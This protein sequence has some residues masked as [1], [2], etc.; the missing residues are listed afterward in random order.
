M[1]KLSLLGGVLPL[2]LLGILLLI[3]LVTVATQAHTY[4]L[5]TDEWMHESYGQASLR[6]YLTLGKDRSFLNYPLEDYEPEHG[7]I[8]DVAVAA[9]QHIAQHQWLTPGRDYGPGRCAG[10]RSHRALWS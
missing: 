7:A 9:V 2:C 1:K 10:R 4:G 8:F 6:W 3:M 5:T